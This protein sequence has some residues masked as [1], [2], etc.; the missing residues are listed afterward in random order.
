MLVVIRRPV[1]CIHGAAGAKQA[2]VRAGA[3]GVPC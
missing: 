2:M 3:R 1:S